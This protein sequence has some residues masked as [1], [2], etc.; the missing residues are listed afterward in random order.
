M[1]A[2]SNKHPFLRL[3]NR[4]MIC[5]QIDVPSGGWVFEVDISLSTQYDTNVSVTIPEGTYF[6]TGHG[7]FGDDLLATLGVYLNNELNT[8]NAT[9]NVYLDTDTQRVGFAFGGSLV[10]TG[11]GRDV[12]LKLSAS[13]STLCSVLGT[14]Q[15]DKTSTGTA[16][17]NFAMDYQPGYVWFAPEDNLLVGF[18]QEP[19]AVPEVIESMSKEVAKSSV[20]SVFTH[21]RRTLALEYVPADSAWSNGTEYLSQPPEPWVKNKGLECWFMEAM[22]GKR[23]RVFSHHLRKLSHDAAYSGTVGSKTT[24]GTSTTFQ[25]TSGTDWPTTPGRWS[26]AVVE[27][28]DENRTTGRPFVTT[29][30][31]GNTATSVTVYELQTKHPFASIASGLDYRI[32]DIFGEEYYLDMIKQQQWEPQEIPGL[33]RF[34]I[35]F[36]LIRSDNEDDPTVSEPT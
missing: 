19:I 24:G 15:T 25:D 33:D 30:S 1:I 8:D 17:P 16:D 3:P 36:Q 28:S 35:Q 13:N 12:R 26:R 2:T 20:V 29:I 27:L 10:K 18:E 22:K 23:F 6:L 4:P 34:S 7:R 31:T 32:Y 9:V 5:T 11:A 21:Y 14:D